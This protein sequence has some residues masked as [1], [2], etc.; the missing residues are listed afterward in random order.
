MCRRKMIICGALAFTVLDCIASSIRTKSPAEL[1]TTADRIALA[2]L[3]TLTK[4]G[5]P[6]NSEE[7]SHAEVAQSSLALAFRD[8]GLLTRYAGTNASE[9]MEQPAIARVA[10]ANNLIVGCECGVNC[11]RNELKCRL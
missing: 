9:A 11:E 2:P 7:M 5:A 4:E 10:A 3:T 8:L 6:L 1:V